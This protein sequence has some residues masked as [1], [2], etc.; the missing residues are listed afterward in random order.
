MSDADTMGMSDDEVA[1]LTAA[2]RDKWK[3]ELTADD[4]DSIVAAARRGIMRWDAEMERAKRR[5]ALGEDA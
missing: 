2:E 5:A 3:D 4:V 1:Y